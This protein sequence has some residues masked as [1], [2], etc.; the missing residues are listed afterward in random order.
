[1]PLI[2]FFSIILFFVGLFGLIV[3]SNAIKS[4]I[5][6]TVL[7][8]A[9]ITFWI[10]IGSRHNRVPPIMDPALGMEQIYYMADPVPQA[11]MI[12]AIV[13]GFSVT[14]INIIMMN[15]TYKRYKTSDWG[16]LFKMAREETVGSGQVLSDIVF[17]KDKEGK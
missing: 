11:L 14:A 16:T 1:M 5:Y 8:S 17:D 6:M 7:N 10:A 2:E 15:T 12:T 13:I 3:S 9:V 4:I